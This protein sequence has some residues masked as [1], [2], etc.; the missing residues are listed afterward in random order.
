MI[1]LMLSG[2]ELGGSVMAPQSETRTL[3]VL[4]R[5]GSELTAFFAASLIVLNMIS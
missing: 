4:L 2:K 1:L 3:Y 5:L